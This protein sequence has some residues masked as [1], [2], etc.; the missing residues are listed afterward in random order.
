MQASEFATE[1]CVL[2]SNHT[3]FRNRFAGALI[4]KASSHDRGVQY[5]IGGMY[6]MPRRITASATLTAGSMNLG[7]AAIV[8]PF[9]RAHYCLIL[10]FATEY[11]T[12]VRKFTAT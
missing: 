1:Q 12:S 9:M 3:R 7:L 5:T 6:P 4:E 2:H 8:L 11:S 10:G